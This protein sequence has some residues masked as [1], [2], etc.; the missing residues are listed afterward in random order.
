MWQSLSKVQLASIVV[1]SVS[2]SAFAAD[3]SEV[4]DT[5]ESP[6]VKSGGFKAQPSLVFAYER[7]TTDDK[8]S[9]SLAGYS[10]GARA[11]LSA[12]E[13]AS[14]T[15]FL[16]TGAHWTSVGN[17]V[18]YK[19]LPGLAQDISSDLSSVVLSVDAGAGLS[20]TPKLNL[21]FVIGFASNVSGQLTKTEK[22]NSTETESKVDLEKFQNASLGASTSYALSDEFSVGADFNYKAAGTLKVKDAAESKYSGFSVGVS[23][24]YTF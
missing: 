22:A 11:K 24:L 19:P 9:E 23:S 3:S 8:G 14:V 6:A 2:F 1:F 10:V 20:V 12:G 18:S 13:F 15:P 16:Q 4:Q 21:D 17:V 7:L 5:Q